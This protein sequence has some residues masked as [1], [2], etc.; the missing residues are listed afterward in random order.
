[1]QEGTLLAQRFDP[2]RLELSGD[3]IPIAEGV[4]ITLGHGY[5]SASAN[6]TLIYRKGGANPAW[7]L[8]WLNRSGKEIGSAGTVGDYNVGDNR[9]LALSPRSGAEH[10][11]T[12]DLRTL[13]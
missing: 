9:A 10:E 5:F 8:R 2:S 7:R 11:F 13:H 6:G 12:P 1:M 4:G 3:P